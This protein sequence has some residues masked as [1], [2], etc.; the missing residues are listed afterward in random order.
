MMCTMPCAQQAR[1]LSSSCCTISWAAFQSPLSR[2]IAASES[3]LLSQGTGLLRLRPLDAGHEPFLEVRILSQVILHGEERVADARHHEVRH[4]PPGFAK[5]LPFG[6]MIV[7][8]LQAW[9]EQAVGLLGDCGVA[10][11]RR[12]QDAMLHDRDHARLDVVGDEKRPLRHPALSLHIGGPQR[13]FVF[14]GEVKVDGGGFPHDEAVV[15]DGRHARV[16]IERHVLGVLAG[17]AL[18]V[19]GDVVVL[20]GDVRFLAQPRDAKRARAVLAIKLEHLSLSL[21]IQSTR[22]PEAATSLRMRSDSAAT[23]RANSS[24][25]WATAARPSC[26]SRSRVDRSRSALAISACSLCTTGRGVADGTAK[27]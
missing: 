18:D 17:C 7:Q 4:V 25:D 1:A 9:L 26:A 21:K 12:E 13:A 19:D 2:N 24:G 8:N 22:A 5:A 11:L 6:K 20:V 3:C 27:P 10:L 15:V 16:G 23:K 14:L